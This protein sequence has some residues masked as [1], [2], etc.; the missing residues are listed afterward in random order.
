MR[1]SYSNGRE[2]IFKS[3]HNQTIIEELT[4]CKKALP[5]KRSNHGQ[6]IIKDCLYIF[7]GLNE[8]DEKLNDLWVY[9][10]DKTF[11]EKV[12]V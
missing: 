8:S 12:E 7:G 11:W 9:Y 1:Y 2:E 3:S 10:I 4:P 5:P 6:C